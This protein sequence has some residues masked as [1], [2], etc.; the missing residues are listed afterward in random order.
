MSEIKSELFTNFT[1]KWSKHS[2]PNDDTCNGAI[3][4]DGLWTCYRAKCAFENKFVNTSEFGKIQTG[5]VQSPEYKSYYW[6]THK[7]HK[8]SIT[9]RDKIF[10]IDAVLYK[11]SETEWTKSLPGRHWLCGR[12]VKYQRTYWEKL[13]EILSSI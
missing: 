13:Q 6:A 3:V 7:G 4:I 12:Q 8:L 2:H 10:K 5:C 1:K 9:V 11:K